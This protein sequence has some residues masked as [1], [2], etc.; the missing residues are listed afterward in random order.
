[1]HGESSFNFKKAGKSYTVKDFPEEGFKWF[2]YN[3][4]N[5]NRVKNWKH[6][7]K[8]AKVRYD[9]SENCLA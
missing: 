3:I 5:K 9:W 4:I 2:Q 1:M 6:N 7:P 8:K